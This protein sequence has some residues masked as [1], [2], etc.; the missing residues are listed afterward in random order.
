ML[1]TTAIQNISNIYV[2]HSDNSA[3]RNFTL[4]K[5]WSDVKIRK[6]EALDIMNQYLTYKMELLRKKYGAPLG[7]RAAHLTSINRRRRGRMNYDRLTD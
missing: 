4:T 6:E 3:Y 5:I 7:G 1:F 2:E